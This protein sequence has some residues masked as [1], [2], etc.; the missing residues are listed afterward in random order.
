MKVIKLAITAVI[1]TSL[2]N[3]A[4]AAGSNIGVVQFVGTIVEPM[5]D[6][7]LEQN[8]LS[9]SCY[10]EGHYQMTRSA[11]EDE[12][13]IPANIGQTQIRWLDSTHKQGVLT[14]SYN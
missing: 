14:V 5:C 13:A 8:Q 9:S 11:V 4:L 12:Q 3:Y 6:V 7:T 10:R 2:S 1:F